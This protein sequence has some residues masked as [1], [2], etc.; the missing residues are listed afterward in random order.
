MQILRANNWTEVRDSCG[1]VRGW[2]EGAEGE[3]KPH[4]KNNHIS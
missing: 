4:R 1:R 3:L 2:T